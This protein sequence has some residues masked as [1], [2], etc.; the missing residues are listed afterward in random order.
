VLLSILEIPQLVQ[1]PMEVTVNTKI[2]MESDSD[3]DMDDIYTTDKS[4]EEYD[5][6]TFSET[7]AFEFN[8]EQLEVTVPLRGS[9]TFE[10]QFV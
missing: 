4:S 7:E 1:E 9:V 2:L 5:S 10:E 6:D 8:L 3:S